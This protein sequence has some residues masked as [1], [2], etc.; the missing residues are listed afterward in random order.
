MDSV[1]AANLDSTLPMRSAFIKNTKVKDVIERIGHQN[2]DLVK[3]ALGPKE[4]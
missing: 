1:E 3:P 4:L 2:P